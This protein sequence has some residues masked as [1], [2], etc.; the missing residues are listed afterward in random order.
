[1]V[2]F[3][4]SHPWNANRFP[5]VLQWKSNEAFWGYHL[6]RTKPQTSN[7]VLKQF[8]SPL[9]DLLKKL[10][11]KDPLKRLGHGGGK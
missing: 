7:T 4:L 9:N 8:N 11:N 1:L 3:R 2:V 6:L 5:S 10:F